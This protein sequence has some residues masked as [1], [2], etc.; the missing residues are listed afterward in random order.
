M[1][2]TQSLCQLRMPFPTQKIKHRRARGVVGN[3]VNAASYPRT[4][5]NLFQAKALP[6][7]RLPSPILY[8]SL[9][10]ITGGLTE[11]LRGRSN[12]GIRQKDKKKIP[13]E[14]NVEHVLRQKAHG[15]ML[16]LRGAL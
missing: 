6:L 8:N 5:K 9:N 7:D 13:F 10:R 11:E 12:L 16:K 14:L 15:E 1:E 2:N 4:C 3:A